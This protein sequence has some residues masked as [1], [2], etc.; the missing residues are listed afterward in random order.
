[1]LRVFLGCFVLALICG[2]CTEELDFD[3]V[4]DFRYEPVIELSLAYYDYLAAD[5]GEDDL[6][7]RT[8]YVDS[9]TADLFSQEFFDDNLKEAEFF[10]RY[11][12][13]IPRSFTTQ[14]DFYNSNNEVV[15]TIPVSI[16][17]Y[18][19]TPVVVTATAYFDESNIYLLKE[20]NLVTAEIVLEA[21][22]PVLT[23][24]SEGSLL[25]ESSGTYYMRFND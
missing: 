19:G 8:V 6:G 20:T 16:P 13:T 18:N 15:Y 4:D 21:G 10:L 3:Q 2:S 17:P 23:P 14:I 12:N 22:S 1:M 11:T 25:F 24:Q 7:G 9:T 5:F